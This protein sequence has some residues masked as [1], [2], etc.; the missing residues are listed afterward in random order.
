MGLGHASE[1]HGRFEYTDPKTGRTG[2]GD[3]RSAAEANAHPS[4]LEHFLTLA[5]LALKALAM[6]VVRPVPGTVLALTAGLAVVALEYSIED[7]LGRLVAQFLVIAFGLHAFGQFLPRLEEAE[8]RLVARLARRSYWTGIAVHYL[9]FAYSAAASWG[10]T[11]LLMRLPGRDSPLL[12]HPV[13]AHLAAAGIVA[14]VLYRRAR[15]HPTLRHPQRR[16]RQEGD[17]PSA[18]GRSA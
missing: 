10:L 12:T 11:I 14:L 2:I 13:L 16:M 4:A 5:F 15:L 9:L 8:G 3:T 7:T 6:S 17:E 18:P 1:K